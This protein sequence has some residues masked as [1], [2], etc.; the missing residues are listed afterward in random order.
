MSETRLERTTSV[1]PVIDPS[2]LEKIPS[3][4][5]DALSSGAMLV[6]EG[7]RLEAA[8][9]SRGSFA[10][11]VFDDVSQDMQIAQKEIFGPVAPIIRAEDDSDAVA[12]TNSTVYGLQASIFTSDMARGLKLA[13]KVKA[14]AVLINDRTN[15]R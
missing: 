3:L 11:T 6:T 7:K 12:K 2:G 9:Y 5:D 1:G 10:S 15:V 8:E 13:R 4:V 14:G